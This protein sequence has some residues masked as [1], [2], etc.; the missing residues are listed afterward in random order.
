MKKK[1][2]VSDLK[3]FDKVLVR[4]YDTDDWDIDF[5]SRNITDGNN[6]PFLG[7]NNTYGQCIPY[8]EET[9]DLLGTDKECPKKYINW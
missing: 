4:D 7:I 5:F 1:F 6:F 3:P 2:A 8:N 9:K